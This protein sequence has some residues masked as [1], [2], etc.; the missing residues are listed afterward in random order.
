MDYTKFG[1]WKNTHATEMQDLTF[2]KPNDIFIFTR[3]TQKVPF[4]F[5]GKQIL[6]AESIEEAMGYIRHIFLYDI[7]ND[8]SDDFEND[9][10]NIYKEQQTD[11]IAV[12]NYWFKLGKVMD[13]K[14]YGCEFEK[15][16]KN[17]NSM[18][19]HRETTEY[20]IQIL[21]G[22][23]ELQRFLIKR[24]SKHKNFNKKTL[25]SVCSNDEFLGEGLK[26]FIN[27]LF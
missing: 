6:F 25:C 12:L 14:N 1:N 21:N 8:I 10:K 3:F 20:E 23:D 16:C 18:F 2:A 11:A 13:L 5:E 9:I 27:L 4:S 15:F 22:A 26:N 24:Y 17:F 7:L 19:S